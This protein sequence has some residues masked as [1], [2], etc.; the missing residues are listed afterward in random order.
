MIIND[1]NIQKF[2]IGSKG[3]RLYL[4]EILDVL[5]IINRYICFVFDIKTS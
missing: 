1:L 5:N 2:N 3:K 4:N